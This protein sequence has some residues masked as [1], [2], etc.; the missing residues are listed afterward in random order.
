MRMKKIVFFSLL[1]LAAVSFS[2]AQ[3]VVFSDNFDTYTVGSKLAQSNSA[4]TTWN[5]A[6]GS[7][8]DGEITNAQAA[9]QP[10]SLLVSGDVDQL[11]PFGNYTTGHYIVAFNMYIP[12]TGNG[13]YF[14]IQHVLKQ[15]WSYEC[16]FYNNGTGYLTV[17]GA[18]INFTYPSNA[19]F[20]VVMDVDLDNDQTSLTINN[21]VVNTWPF[22]YTGSATYGGANQLAGIDLYAGAPNDLTG[23]YY[24]D[25]FTVTE[26]SAALV[27]EFA[28]N[29]TTLSTSLAPNTTGT[30]DLNFSNPGTNSTEYKIV[31]TYDIPNPDPTS[32][33]GTQLAYCTDPTT[34]IGFNS[35]TQLDLAIG[36]PSSSLQSHIGETLQMIAVYLNNGDTL[37]GAKI[38]VFG[39]SNPLWLEGPGEML[40]EQTFVPVDGWNYVNLTTPVIIDG[41]DLWFGAWIDQPAGAFPISM[42]EYTSADD[43]N[44][45]YRTGNTWHKHFTNFEYALSIVGF[46][47]GTPITPWL[48][49]SPETGS[50][51]AGGTASPTLTANAAGM[52]LGETHTAHLHCYSSDFNNKEVVVPVTLTITNV[53]VDEHNRIAVSLYPN[54][55]VDQMQISADRVLRVEVFNLA[56]QKMMDNEY[57]DSRVVL[58]ASHLTSG[59]YMVTV[60]TNSGKTTKKVVVR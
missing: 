1:M 28:V 36:F 20:P 30:L 13:G 60:T 54:P 24:V 50:I 34:H 18:D 45:W 31:T 56:G 44:A 5:D 14:N 58:D 59:T 46:I 25:D 26:V 48:T 55:T 7:S 4:W 9:S 40:Y 16:Y 57:N 33:G 35:A 21:V 10:N 42:D 39:M 12:S 32:T 8:E 41:S 37:T 43:Y 27:G 3:T 23:T 47:D 53:E 2:V 22:H 11:Y 6:P 15:Q 49:V 51:A 19:W 52:A 38:R 29:P 17:G